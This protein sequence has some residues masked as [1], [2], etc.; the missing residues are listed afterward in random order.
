M[1]IFIELCN[2]KDHPLGGHLSFAKHLTCAMQGDLHLVGITTDSSE[3]IHQWYK[4]KIEGSIYTVFNVYRTIKASNKPLIPTRISDYYA[5]KKCINKLR[6]E[7]F[8]NIIIQ[9]PEVLLALPK[10]FLPKVILIMPGV[11]NPLSISR[12]KLARNFQRPYDKIFFNRAYK[13]HQ[14]L[15]AADMQSIKKFIERSN[16][17]IIPQQIAQ[18]PTRYDGNIFNIKDKISLRKQYG[19]NLNTKILVTTGRLNWFKG[20]KFMIDS[21]VLFLRANPDSIL[22]F[23]GDGED[24]DKISTYISDLHLPEHVKLIGYQSLNVISEYLNMADLFIMGSYKEGWSTSLVEAV[25]CATPCVVTE[26][27]SASE[28]VQD[29]INGYVVYER[30]EQIFATKMNDALSLPNENIILAANQIQNLAVA[31]MKK[32]FEKFLQK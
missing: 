23:I 24:R 7:K 4:K 20:W 11:E 26:F 19:F 21:F 8:K 14:I 2:F 31:N 17:L 29:N 28:M 10:K 9:T 6:L 1:N 22:F 12:Y 30:N 5:L 25:S 27:S 32:E 3:P 15:A 18:F 13:V 16:G